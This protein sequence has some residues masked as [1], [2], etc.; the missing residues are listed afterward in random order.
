MELKLKDGTVFTVGDGSYNSSI[1]VVGSDRTVVSKLFEA[2]TK[3]NL[4]DFALG[5]K[6][7]KNMT[8]DG[9]NIVVEDSG[10]M[11]ARFYLRYLTDA[12][13]N[14]EI[15]KTITGGDDLTKD[16]AETIRKWVEDGA[17]KLDD[18]ESLKHP[19]LF[20]DWS[21]DGVKYTA[22][23]KVL[24]NGIL[25][26]VLQDNTSQENWNPKD[27]HSLFSRMLIPDSSKIYE[28]EQPHA[29]NTYQKGDKVSHN[30]KTW[31]SLV[32][33]NAWE[34]TEANSTLWKEIVATDNDN[35]ASS[36]GDST[37]TIPDFVQPTAA[38]VYKKGTKVK[39]NGKIYES[40]IDNNSWSPDAYPQGWKE[41]TA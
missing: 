29:E 3:D 13:K 23:T 38:T 24:Y 28:W 30:G 40:L 17:Q 39:Y 26:K 10:D 11:T 31:E 7:L 22:G 6:E 4:S 9:M 15:A 21:K 20:P 12:E 32:D 16:D 36:S 25:Y 5:G 41:V 18:D 14:S 37:E 1:V 34:P 2:L 33:N 27:A 35:S 8:F 19:N